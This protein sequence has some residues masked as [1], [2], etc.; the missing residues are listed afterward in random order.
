MRPTVLSLFAGLGGGTLGFLQAGFRCVG[1]LECLRTLG[2][3]R[4]GGLLLSGSPVWVGPE[5]VGVQGGAS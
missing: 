4:A 1:A 2:A 3:S 5:R